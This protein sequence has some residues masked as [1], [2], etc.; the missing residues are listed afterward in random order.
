MR[1]TTLVSAT[2]LALSTSAAASDAIQQLSVTS[3]KHTLSPQQIQAELDSWYQS[4][5]A[6][7][8]EVAN[9]MSDR[10]PLIVRKQ[11]AKDKL[12]QQYANLKA[13]FRL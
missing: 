7:V 1:I 9:R 2:L 4:E 6:N 11:Q 8:D 13:D 5:L 10:V 3:I 12:E